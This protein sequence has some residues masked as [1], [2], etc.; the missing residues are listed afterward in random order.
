[1]PSTKEAFLAGFKNPGENARRTAK[2]LLYGDSGVGKTVL[3]ASLGQDIVYVDSAEGW[4]SLSNHPELL[5]KVRRLEYQGLSQ[6]ETLATYIIDGSVQCDTLIV[7]EA[8]TIAILDLDT[9]LASRSQRDASKDPDVPTQPD[10]FANTERCRRAFL[11][12][13]RLPINVV[14]VAHLREDKD[15][16]TGVTTQRPAFSP[17]LRASIEQNCHLVARL[18]ANEKG[19]EYV[20]KMQTQPIRGVDAKSRIGGLDRVVENP[21]L[22]KILADWTETNEVPEMSK[23]PDAVTTT[24]TSDFPFGE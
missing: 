5:A 24:T 11:K 8:S 20:R 14:F 7:D 13:L 22:G 12:L 6:L 21:D 2:V 16:R 10:F 1:M 18:T 17:K 23:T 4:V 19:G 9:V 15:E 3:A